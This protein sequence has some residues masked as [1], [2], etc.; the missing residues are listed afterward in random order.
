[1][2]IKLEDDIRNIDIQKCT[3]AIILGKGPTFNKFDN[4]HLRYNNLFISKKTKCFK[5]IKN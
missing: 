1:M 2:K 4:I 3:K 5:I